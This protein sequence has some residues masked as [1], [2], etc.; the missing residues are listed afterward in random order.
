[1]QPN[2]FTTAARRVTKLT[3]KA[4]AALEERLEATGPSK[5]RK[6]DAKGASVVSKN[7]KKAKQNPPTDISKDRP[8][9]GTSKD[10]PVAEASSPP[11]DVGTAVEL[12]AI[13]RAIVRTEEEE[14]ALYDNAIV[15]DEESEKSGCEAGNEASGPESAED[16]RTTE[17]LMKEWVSPVYAF[18][19]PTPRITEVGGRRAH[20]FK[21]HAKGCKATI[22]QFLDKK[23]A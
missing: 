13:R 22:R 6:I 2:I 9:I 21:C 17:R 1:M 20:E 10:R 18:F 19:D 3:D 15:I 5:K 16:E 8:V 11:P 23:D 4:K 12:R 7:S 14:K